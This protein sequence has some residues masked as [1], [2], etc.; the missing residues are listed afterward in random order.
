MLDFFG[1][2][3]RSYILDIS[4]FD[5]LAAIEEIRKVNE[6]PRTWKRRSEAKVW[7]S[8]ALLDKRVFG[9]SLEYLSRTSDFKISIPKAMDYFFSCMEVFNS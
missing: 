3:Q 7:K 2:L 4:A 1:L 9:S 5:S 6:S 8:F